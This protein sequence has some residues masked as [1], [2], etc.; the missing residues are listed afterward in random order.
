MGGPWTGRRSVLG[1]SGSVAAYKAAEVTSRLVQA[2][3]EVDVAM[4][5][6]ATEFI[7]PLTFRSLTARQ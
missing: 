7:T 1:V 3:A 6:A 4:T 2:G 5:Q